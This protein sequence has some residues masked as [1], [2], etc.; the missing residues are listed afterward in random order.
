M[1]KAIKIDLTNGMVTLDDGSKKTIDNYI[2]ELEDRFIELQEV[3]LK[4]EQEM[5]KLNSI[6]E[7]QDNKIAK[8]NSENVCLEVEMELYKDGYILDKDSDKEWKKLD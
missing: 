7:W 6:I 3:L 8:L 1:K 4:Q 2:L 5:K